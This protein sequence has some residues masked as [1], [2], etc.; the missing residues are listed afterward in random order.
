MLLP[1]QRAA[2]ETIVEGIEPNPLFVVVYDTQGVRDVAEGLGVDPG[3]CETV[4]GGVGWFRITNHLPTGERM[5]DLIKEAVEEAE[6]I[7]IHAGGS[8][9]PEPVFEFMLF[10]RGEKFSTP[11][12]VFVAE[13]TDVRG[14]DRFMRLLFTAD[15]ILRLN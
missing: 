6:W 14:G 1:R 7:F 5:I 9:C 15:D 8:I 10:L 12:F 13:A 3:A 11:R 4:T 2:L